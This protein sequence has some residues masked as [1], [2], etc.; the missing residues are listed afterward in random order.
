MVEHSAILRG[1]RIEDAAW[2]VAQLSD[3]E[4]LRFTTESA[5]TS[6]DQFRDALA[7]LA[8][9]PGQAGF[10]IV[11]PDT[12]DLVGNIAAALDETDGTTAE[13]SYWVAAEARGRGLAT[14]AVR[15]LCSWVRENW[16][17]AQEVALWTHADNIASQ[18]VA[19]A[20]GFHSQQSQDG[21]RTVAGQQWPVR[22]YTLQLR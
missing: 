19:L 4:I 20:A 10:A 2:Y 13:I 16:P 1:W 7:K 3:Q 15:E 5:D 18:R 6:T 9:T 17:A 14:Q 21:Y 22:W 8:V 11:Q 12:G